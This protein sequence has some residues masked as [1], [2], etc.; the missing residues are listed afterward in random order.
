MGLIYKTP[1]SSGG[2]S[3]DGVSESR[4]NQLITQFVQ[5]ISQNI[6]QV[7]S[8]IEQIKSDIDELGTGGITTEVDP[9]FT[10]WKSVEYDISKASLNMSI[11]NINNSLNN[12]YTKSDINS[13]QTSQTADIIDSCNSA[14]ELAIGNMQAQGLTQDQITQIINAMPDI[15]AISQSN[16]DLAISQAITAANGYT[17]I[18]VL[19]S[20]SEIV[21][22]IT[23]IQNTLATHMYTDKFRWQDVYNDIR[24]SMIRV[25]KTQGMVPDDSK[26]VTSPAP[27]GDMTVNDDY[28]GILG[29]TFTNTATTYTDI[30]LNGETVYSSNGFTVGVPVTKYYMLNKGDIISATNADT[31]EYTPWKYDPTIDPVADMKKQIADQASKILAINARFENKSLSANKIDIEAQSTTLEGYIVPDSLGG[32]IS[33]DGVLALLLSASH[34]DVNGVPVYDI[35]GLKVGLGPDAMQPVNVSQG[36]IITSGGMTDLFYTP[37]VAQ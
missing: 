35:R 25:G 10:S 9:S 30:I 13:L 32:Q 21:V 7:Q 15:D 29:I 20:Q 5:P 11:S 36:D 6:Y 24:L 19:N 17:D 18:Q 8:D 14:I 28:G 34:V 16:L 12:V 2:G 23:T 3:G 4:V 1:S 33:G 26:T 22:P 27:S 31:F 37:Y